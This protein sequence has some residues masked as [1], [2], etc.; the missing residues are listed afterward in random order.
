MTLEEI[1]EKLHDPNEHAVTCDNGELTKLLEELKE[2]RAAERE[3]L[4]TFYPTKCEYDCFNCKCGGAEAT[5][6]MYVSINNVQRVCSITAASVMTEEEAYIAEIIRNNLEKMV[7]ADVQYVEWI[8]CKDKMPDT[9]EQGMDAKYSDCC[10]VCD[11]FGWIG[12]GYYLTDG[13]KSWWEFADAQ[14]KNKI[15]WT[16]ITHWMPL[17]KPPKEGTE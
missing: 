10:L 13:K 17:P 6:N 12:M 14:N 4:M 9:P 2:R 7:A 8:S 11:D 3:C 15:D 5:K 16:E 1:L